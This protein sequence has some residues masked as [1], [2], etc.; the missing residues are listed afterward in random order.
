[1]RNYL[2]EHGA[3]QSDAPNYQKEFIAKLANLEAAIVCNHKRTPPK[4][5]E[6]NLE[7][8]RQAAEKLRGTKPDV[9]KLRAQIAPKEKTLAKLLAAQP[10]PEK[11]Q[12]QLKAREQAL[13]NARAALAA[14]PDFDAQI[15]ARQAA[16][17]Q[18][19]NELKQAEPGLTAVLKK[20]QTALAALK[21]PK[22]KKALAQFNKRLRAAKRAVSE[23]KKTNDAKLGRLKQRV[24]NA[25]KA[26][27]A[28]TRAKR[29]KSRNAAKK[30]VNAEKSFKS[31]QQAVEKGPQ[32]YA[33]RVA[34]AKE[35]VEKAKHAPDLAL[36]NFEE[37]VEKAARQYEL[38]NKTRDYNL[39]TS[40]KNYIDPRVYKSWGDH[41]EFEWQR[42]YTTALKRKFAW[43][44]TERTHWSE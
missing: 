1:M 27:E 17:D 25:R 14:L 6:E 40:L 39:G 34:K 41:V 2:R 23:T 3:L 9:S 42:L 18:A 26:L 5:W 22:S 31:A 33:E 32:K 44:E 21:P 30:V 19:T 36:K 38:A 13:Q 37:R 12:E 24:T 11:L 29:E 16:F 7:K 10:D 28:A 43:V 4:N 15:K 8:K 20:K 35:A